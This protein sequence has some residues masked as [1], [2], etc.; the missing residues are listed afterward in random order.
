MTTGGGGAPTVALQPASLRHGVLFHGKRCRPAARVRGSQRGHT[1]SRRPVGAGSVDIPTQ[2]KRPREFLSREFVKSHL[3]G[4]HH[5][6]H[7]VSWEEG[8]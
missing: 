3:W 4:M 2:V 7:S 5:V 8:S 6:Q 1:E